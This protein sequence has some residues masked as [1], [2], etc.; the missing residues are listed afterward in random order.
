[1]GQEGSCV[2]GEGVGSLAYERRAVYLGG[3]GEEDDR[4]GLRGP[5]WI[6]WWRPT[7]PSIRD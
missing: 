2:H 7:R 5:E 6:S 1:M 4:V 3:Q